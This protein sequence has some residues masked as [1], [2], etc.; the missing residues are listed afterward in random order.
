MLDDHHALDTKMIATPMAVAISM[1]MVQPIA[2]EDPVPTVDASAGWPGW[3]DGPSAPW[4]GASAPG[5][6]TAVV[7]SWR[8]G[9]SK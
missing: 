7:S 4:L 8:D 9:S 5:E 2:M 3:A 6:T 1:M